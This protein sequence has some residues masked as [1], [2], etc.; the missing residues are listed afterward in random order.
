M[1]A[2]LFLF[3]FDK[4]L[5]AYD[6]RKRLP[7]LAELSGVSQYDL[8]KHWWAA[9]REEAAESGALSVDRGVPRR[10]QR[11]DRRGAHGRAGGA[12]PGARR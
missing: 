4:T 3:D 6:F 12:R 8:A 7:R 5:Y 9:G 11:G 1:G 10:V 2:P